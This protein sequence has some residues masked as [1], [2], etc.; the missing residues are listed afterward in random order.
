M[1][2]VVLA[3][4]GRLGDPALQAPT[5]AKL[6][7]QWA[8]TVKSNTVRQ[9]VDV[10]SPAGGVKMRRT[11]FQSASTRTGDAVRPGSIERL[12]L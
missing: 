7:L 2:Q 1:Q 4:A 10:V 9:C 3:P 5:G 8:E 12:S 11:P 6:T